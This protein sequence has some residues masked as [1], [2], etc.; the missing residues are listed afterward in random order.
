MALITGA[1]KGIGREL[2]KV[3]AKNGYSLILIARTTSELESLQ[4]ELKNTYQCT[5]KILPLDLSESNAVDEIMNTFKEDIINLDVLVNNAGFGK[6]SKFTNMS[7]EDVEGM[8][9][10]NIRV[11]TEL[12]YRVLPY[13]TAKKQGKIL[14]VASIAAYAPGPYMA[15]YYA[16]KAYVLSFSVA[17]Y[18][19]YKNDGVI[20]SALCPGYTE[21]EFQA[22]AGLK[23]A[24]MMD[25]MFPIMTA[26][27]VATIG[28]DQLMKNKSVIITGMINKIF[29]FL[30]WLFPQS[31]NAKITAMICKPRN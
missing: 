28:Y 15:M 19:E 12:T 18:E 31:L 10:V 7:K 30:L 8:L 21:T 29:V 13:M 5:S 6:S 23:G 14:N 4:Q 27:Q 11:L 26:E 9:A 3:F 2:A 1:S 25:R 16:T 24:A 17:L 22:R 20:I